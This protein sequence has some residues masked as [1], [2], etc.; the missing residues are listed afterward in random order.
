MEDVLGPFEID[1]AE[2]I[3]EG[4]PG[5]LTAIET[6]RD[7]R[8]GTLNVCA[9]RYSRATFLQTLVLQDAGRGYREIWSRMLCPDPQHR[10]SA[11]SILRGPLCRL[12]FTIGPRGFNLTA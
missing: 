1:F 2:S 5:I 11:R 8:C 3:D 7:V 10:A 9:S 12:Y 4:H 6:S